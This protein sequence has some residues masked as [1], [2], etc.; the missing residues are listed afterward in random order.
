M[1]TE[2]ISSPSAPRYSC[3]LSDFLYAFPTLFSSDK[4]TPNTLHNLLVH[5]DTYR[6]TDNVHKTTAYL[7]TYTFIHVQY[8]LVE[9]MSQNIHSLVLLLVVLLLTLANRTQSRTAF[10][11]NG[12]HNSENGQLYRRLPTTT[13]TTTR[14]PSSSSW[15]ARNGAI[16]AVYEDKRQRVIGALNGGAKSTVTSTTIRRDGWMPGNDD[17][18]VGDDVIRN[19]WTNKWNGKLSGVYIIIICAYNKQIIATE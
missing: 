11:T 15:P 16:P 3:T 2:K 19:D 12:Q 8:T 17:G 9:I 1:Y 18:R 14:R 5:Q 13:T 6:H 10:P 7:Y 4:C